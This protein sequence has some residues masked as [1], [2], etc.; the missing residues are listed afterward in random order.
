MKK[1]EFILLAAL[2]LSLLSGCKSWTSPEPIYKEPENIHGDDYYQALREYKNSEH[3]ICFG[4]FSGWTGRGADMLNQLR[5]I[6]DSMDVVSHWNPVETYVEPLTED[7]KSDLE[8]VHKK[9]TKV[10]FCLFFKNLGFRLTPPEVTEGMSQGSAGYNAAMAE[11]W[12]WYKHGNNQY[13]GS[14]AAEDAMR[15]YAAAMSEYVI[16]QG[17]DGIDFDYE[18]HW[19]EHGNLVSSPEA[20]HVFIDELSKNFGPKSG[21][22]RILAVDGEPQSLLAETGPMIDYY[23]I[24]SYNSRGDSDLD[25][26][27]AGTGVGGTPSLVK[28]FGTVESE[29]EILR[30]TVWTETFEGSN[31]STGGPTFTTR[32]GETTFSM[33]GMA[34]YYRPGIEA[35]L[36]GFGAYRFDLCRPINDYLIMRSTIQ[37]VNPSEHEHE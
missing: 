5:G 7:Q 32:D 14:V 3:T 2:S 1:R 8:A 13:D 16:S 25:N 15:K 4:W 36:G 34:L 23:I 9:G 12:G 27:F 19:G 35:K 10:L 24:Q 21:T 11:Y 37:T 33:R 20:I 30:K 28:K 6:P 26:R 22:G 29:A 17:Y 31:K 18:Y